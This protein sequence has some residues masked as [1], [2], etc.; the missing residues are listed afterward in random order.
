MEMKYGYEYMAQ[1]L[2]KWSEALSESAERG[3]LKET[4]FPHVWGYA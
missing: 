1:D 2:E 3:L 4:F